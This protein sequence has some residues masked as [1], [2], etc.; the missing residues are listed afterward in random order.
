MLSTPVVPLLVDTAQHVYEPAE[1]LF[2]LLDTLEAQREWLAEHAFA[3]RLPL[4]VEVGVGSGVVALF[5]AQHAIVPGLVVYGTDV[6]PHACVGARA[7]AAHNHT[8]IETIETLLT[9]AI[10]PQLV[11]L[12]VFNP[13]YVPAEAV[14]SLPSSPSSHHWL[15]LALDG[16]NDGMEVTQRLLDQLPAVLAP[17]GVAY[18][19][20]CA[21]NLLDQVLAAT[22]PT[23]AAT[24]VASRKCAWEV[25]LVVRYIRSETPNPT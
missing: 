12:V 2:L 6:N 21:R 7:T 19:L 23:L 15:D 4:V 5:L 9:T 20:F 11:D 13:P 16:G 10:R 8:W 22:P 1:D 24:V 17:N 25:L 3:H 14:P 18:V